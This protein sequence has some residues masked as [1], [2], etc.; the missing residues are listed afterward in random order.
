MGWDILTRIMALRVKDLQGWLKIDT[1]T[2]GVMVDEK[3]D[4]GVHVLCSLIRLS[5]SL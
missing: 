2:F 3:R 5:Y 1:V 4:V